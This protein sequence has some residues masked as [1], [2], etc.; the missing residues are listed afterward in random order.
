VK[1]EGDGEEGKAEVVQGGLRQCATGILL[2]IP[3]PH[4]RDAGGTLP[5]ALEIRQQPADHAA[6]FFRRPLMVQGHE[7]REDGLFEGFGIGTGAG[8]AS[9]GT[10]RCSA[11]L[12]IHGITN[13]FFLILT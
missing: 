11:S 7:A 10:T 8:Q 6:L 5:G 13:G 12:C 3:N 2:V 4:R 9:G 1:D